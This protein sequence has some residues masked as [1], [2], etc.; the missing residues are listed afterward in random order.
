MKLKTQQIINY[1]KRILTQNIEDGWPG[2][3]IK[4]NQKVLH[5]PMCFDDFPPEIEGIM[6]II[7]NEIG[8]GNAVTVAVNFIIKWLETI[9]CI[10]IVNIQNSV[11]VW[12]VLLYKNPVYW[13]LANKLWN[14][15]FTDTQY[16]TKYRCLHW[17]EKMNREEASSKSQ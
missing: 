4:W 11:K 2:I 6:P 15:W 17:P 9:A 8:M 7:S 1:E 5:Q 13:V 10:R 14:M 3:N 12:Q 16:T